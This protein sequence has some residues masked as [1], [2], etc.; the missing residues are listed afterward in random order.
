MFT[1]QPFAAREL[2]NSSFLVADPEA[3]LAA[4]IDP[5]RD[6]DGYLSHAESHVLSIVRA[7]DTHVH[8]D[9]VSGAR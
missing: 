7:L 1:V 8:N 2:G 3:G 4:V 9:F 6:V 5:F